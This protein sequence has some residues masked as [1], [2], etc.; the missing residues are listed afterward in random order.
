MGQR[1]M[2]S[3]RVLVVDDH[4]DVNMMLVDALNTLGHSCLGVESAQAAID[5]AS[6]FRPEVIVLEWGLRAGDGRNLPRQLRERAA[7]F[8]HDLL[9]IVLTARDP[10]EDFEHA[11]IDAFIMK[12]APLARIVEM[13]DG[14]QGD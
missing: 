8:G 14:D 5:V 9:I 10:P 2:R 3:R 6:T 12:P 1:V 7:P 13:L 11:Q 4:A